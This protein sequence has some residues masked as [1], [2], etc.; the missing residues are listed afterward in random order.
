MKRT[1][2]V[3]VFTEHTRVHKSCLERT[4]WKKFGL[5]QVF[6]C[7]PVSCTEL[8]NPLFDPALGCDNRFSP[9]VLSV[10]ALGCHTD[11]HSVPSCANVLLE[12]VFSI[13]HT[14]TADLV[15]ESKIWDPGAEG[16]LVYSLAC[17]KPHRFL[18][19]P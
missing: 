12:C 15:L 8:A 6:T 19:R 1:T 10:P 18:P 5:A 9:C 3:K 14:F 11:V 7:L 2:K 4:K 17:Q 13:E 16:G